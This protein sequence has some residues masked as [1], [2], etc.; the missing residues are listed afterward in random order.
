MATVVTCDFPGCD[1]PAAHRVLALPIRPDGSPRGRMSNLIDVCDGHLH[2]VVLD[3]SPE[4][5]ETT[6]GTPEG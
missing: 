5:E 3:D 4:K 1:E 2:R 6:D